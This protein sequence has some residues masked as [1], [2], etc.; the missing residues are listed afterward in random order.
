M[1]CQEFLN[2]VSMLRSTS[3]CDRQSS[4]GPLSMVWSSPSVEVPEWDVCCFVHR[5]TSRFCLSEGT[6]RWHC[7]DGLNPTQRVNGSAVSIGR[8][9]N[10]VKGP[11]LR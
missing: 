10:Y 1:L 5:N 2:A 6:A 11:A 8:S 4:E 3:S 7:P 9:R